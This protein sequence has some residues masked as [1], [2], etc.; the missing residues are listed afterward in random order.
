MR[1]NDMKQWLQ[2]NK[3]NNNS[4]TDDEILQHAQKRRSRAKPKP[5]V[6]SSMKQVVLVIG[7]YTNWITHEMDS[8]PFVYHGH[9]TSE[10]GAYRGE[11][12]IY[13][14]NTKRY[15]DFL[16]LMHP[17]PFIRF[18][19]YDKYNDDD[20]QDESIEYDGD[21]N[22]LIQI[23]AT[24][25]YITSAYNPANWMDENKPKH[26]HFFTRIVYS[27]GKDHTE[28]GSGK[29]GMLT[30]NKLMLHLYQDLFM[31]HEARCKR[32]GLPH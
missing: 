11:D 4:V 28:C 17:K 19:D 18:M 9:C 14:P 25:V 21:K 23:K 6:T 30:L 3:D 24:Q 12:I 16:S 27:N 8:D 13:V 31:P 1:V 2:E 29:N 26:W 22:T 10:T 20:A 7:D 32:L 5:V 15:D